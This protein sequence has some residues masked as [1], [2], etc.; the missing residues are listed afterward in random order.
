MKSFK[1]FLVES[2]I[3]E[4]REEIYR[5]IMSAITQLEQS[6]ADRAE[7]I[8]EALIELMQ[9][10]SIIPWD[11]EETNLQ[12]IINCIY[13]ALSVNDV[14]PDADHIALNKAGGGTNLYELGQHYIDKIGSSGQ[15]LLK[16]LAKFN[17]HS[18]PRRGELF[19]ALINLQNLYT[20]SMY[21]M[22][23][24]ALPLTQ[25][26]VDAIIKD[27][28]LDGIVVGDRK[29]L[30]FHIFLLLITKCIGILLIILLF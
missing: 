16:Q 24:D 19:D 17:V 20:N 15:H 26:N 28:N 27:L 4:Y 8:E 6:Y 21:R 5:K 23:K 2:S 30:L 25:Q 3:R 18:D 29:M 11:I 10:Q 14:P 7:P 1:Q 12:H 13:H 9:K 22:A